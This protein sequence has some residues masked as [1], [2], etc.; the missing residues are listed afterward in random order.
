MERAG[1]FEG[2]GSITGIYTVLV[3]GDDMNEPISDA[4]RGILDGHVVLSRKLAVKNHFP[5]VD[6]LASISRLFSTLAVPEQKQLVAKIRDL[7]SVYNDAEDLI[8]IGAYTK[9][10]ST[11]IDQAIQFQPPIQAFLRQAVAEGSS[12]HQTLLGMGQIFG[13]DLTPY[14]KQNV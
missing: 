2:R 10:S 9:G 11:S 5:A 7:M 14:L 1:T 12:F 13:V 8:Q 4:V 3:E 6:V